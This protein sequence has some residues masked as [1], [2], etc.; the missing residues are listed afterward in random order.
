VKGDYTP[1]DSKNAKFVQAV[2]EMNVRLNMQKLRERSLVLRE[3]L[4]KGE[5][6]MVGAIYDVS[7]GRVAFWK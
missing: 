2:T 6:E 3:M 4:D 1:R 7:N 5:I